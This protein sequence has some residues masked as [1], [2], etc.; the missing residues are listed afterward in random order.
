MD[1]THCYNVEGQMEFLM[2]LTRS[3]DFN[4]KEKTS[5]VDPLK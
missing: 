1:Y 3:W 5:N 2:G 4:P